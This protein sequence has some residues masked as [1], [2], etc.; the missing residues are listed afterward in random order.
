MLF[1]ISSKETSRTHRWNLVNVLWA[2]QN[3]WDRIISVVLILALFGT[4][5]TVIYMI[6]TPKIEDRFT[7]FYILSLEGD[8]SNYPRELILGE[9]CGVDLGIVN[10][11]HETTVYRV[12]VTDGNE[13]VNEIGP[14]TLNHEER[15]EQE[16]IFACSRVGM[17]QKVDFYL[18][19]QGQT[20]VY[21]VLC[22]WVDVR[23]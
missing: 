17:R 12:E 21:R 6:T 3:R 10:R 7:E 5:G 19:K 13:K 2:G 9:E 16:V 22:L 8:A 11:E 4:I 1:S 15:W 23:G 18:Y 14:I 20:E